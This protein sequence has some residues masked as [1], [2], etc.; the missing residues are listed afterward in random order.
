MSTSTGGERYSNRRHRSIIDIAS[1]TFDYRLVAY[2]R[3][4]VG[5][6]QQA[7]QQTFFWLRRYVVRQTYLK[8]ANYPYTFVFMV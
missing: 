8:M 7:W 6:A 5:Y 3:S 2:G 4:A 1:S